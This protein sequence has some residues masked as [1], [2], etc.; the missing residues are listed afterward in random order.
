MVLMTRR[1]LSSSEIT[2]NA[3]SISAATA[4]TRYASAKGRARSAQQLTLMCVTHHEHR[5][6]DLL[7]VALGDEVSKEAE[8]VSAFVVL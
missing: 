4:H 7:H 8:H 3:W 1:C 2:A 6:L 5:K